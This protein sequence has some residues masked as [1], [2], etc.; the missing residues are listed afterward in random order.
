M[1]LQPT[2]GV[3]AR[4]SSLIENGLLRMLFSPFFRYEPTLRD[5]PSPARAT[6]IGMR[7]S[8]ADPDLAVVASAWP[9]LTESVRAGIVAMVD[10]GPVQP[11]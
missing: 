5:F 6:D 9:E 7:P 2:K 4:L 3:N 11:D 1:R 8:P 10:P